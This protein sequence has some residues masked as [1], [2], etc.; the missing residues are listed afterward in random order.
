VQ[1]YQNLSQ[2]S[3]K[4]LTAGAAVIERQRGRLKLI[5]SAELA[6]TNIRLQYLAE[7][8]L[9]AGQ[10]CIL[11]GGKKTLKTNI[12]IDLVL[13]L[14]NAGLFLGKFKVPEAVRVALLSGESGQATIAETA[15]RIANSKGWSLDHFENARWGFNSCFSG[16]GCRNK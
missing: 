9:V 11:A 3:A 15:R 14:A 5:S 10:P 7:P 13:S 1:L 8:V 6:A 2:N 12:L 16:T 4:G